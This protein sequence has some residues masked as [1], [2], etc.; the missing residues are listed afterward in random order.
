MRSFSVHSLFAVSF[1]LVPAFGAPRA[2]DFTLAQEKAT[3]PISRRG[4]Q[5][6]KRAYAKY[7]A[8]IPAHLTRRDQQHSSEQGS[9]SNQPY[10]FQGVDDYPDDEYLTVISIG[11]P[12]QNIKIDPDTGSSDL[13]VYSTDTPIDDGESNH[14]HYK[15]AKSSTSKKLAGETY[16]I[17]YGD[18]SS[19]SGIVYTDV[20]SVAGISYPKQ[21]VE[22]ATFVSSDFLS[23]L[24]FDGFLGLGHDGGNQIIPTPQ[25]TF[26]TNIAPLLTQP[27]FTASLNHLNPG[28]YD[29]GFIDSRKYTG[30]LKFYPSLQ[31]PAGHGWWVVNATGFASG[32][33]AIKSFA[34]GLKAIIDT[35]TTFLLMPE[36]Y[37]DAYY[38]TAPFAVNDPDDGWV[39]PCKKTL[40]DLTL[41]IGTYKARILGSMMFGG[42]VNSTTCYAALNPIAQAEG[43][44]NAVFGDT[45]LKTTFTVFKYPPGGSPSLGFASKPVNTSFP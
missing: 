30:P 11:T 1:L 45:F 41:E 28:F 27:L 14:T 43:V 35:G 32:N 37:V 23:D 7:G 19:S 36:T 39:Y 20:V 24:R 5:A 15:P 26:F 44:P 34:G 21:A 12:P 38:A 4:P 18:G 31:P 10:N 3:I 22:S 17:Q 25:K 2:A 9:V 29:F 6:L 13:W 16:S 40:P 33:S 8:P 42:A